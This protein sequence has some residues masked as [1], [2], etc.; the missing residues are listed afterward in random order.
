MSVYEIYKVSKY[1]RILDKIKNEKDSYDTSFFMG[2][3]F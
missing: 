1:K 2:N 3:N